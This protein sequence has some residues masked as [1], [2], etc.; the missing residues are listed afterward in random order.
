MNRSIR[1]CFVCGGHG[2]V[3][4]S[5]AI[6]VDFLLHTLEDQVDV[7]RAVMQLVLANDHLLSYSESGAVN[8]WALGKAGTFECLSTFRMDSHVI[9]CLAFSPDGG[10]MAAGG[11]EGYDGFTHGGHVKLFDAQTGQLKMTMWGDKQVNCVAFSPDG[12]CIASGD[13]GFRERGTVRLFNVT[14]GQVVLTLRVESEV[15]CVRFSPD[16][17]RIAVAYY[18]SVQLFRVQT[19]A[20][21]LTEVLEFLEDISSIEFSPD[22]NAIALGCWDDCV[23]LRDAHTGEPIG[24]LLRGHSRCDFFLLQ[25][26]SV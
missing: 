2:H 9:G 21:V 20:Q 15:G 24:M 8:V 1:T 3:A 23:H 26:Q 6:L 12:N 11:G 25:L 10:R 4:G 5:C 14:T 7:V 22:G 19:G 18:N 17:E 16:G 13:G